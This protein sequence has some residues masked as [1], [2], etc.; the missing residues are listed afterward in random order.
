MR[1]D[2]SGLSPFTW[3]CAALLFTAL[4]ATAGYFGFVL[5][6]PLPVV[7]ASIGCWAG[8]WS[9]GV[10]GRTRLRPFLLICGLLPVLL[11]L[12][13]AVSHT[14]QAFDSPLQDANLQAIDRWLGFDWLT[15]QRAAYA[16]PHLFDLLG[17]AYAAFVPQIIAVPLVLCALG[18]VR[19][20]DVVLGAGILA[21]LVVLAVGAALPA[22]GAVSFV[23]GAEGH[24]AYH[25]GATPL[26]TFKALRDGS[27]RRVL[28]DGSGG[29]ITCPSFHCV[30]AVICTYGA[31]GIRPLRWP[32][33]A[34]NAAMIVAAVTH[35]A[36]YLTDVIVGVGLGALAVPASI[37]AS[38]ASLALA[39]SARAYSQR[40]AAKGEMAR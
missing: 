40:P 16:Q 11:C 35:G 2:A 20:A 14:V 22:M 21:Q 36:H 10:K 34:L 3:A 25:G 18:Q 4:V 13:L 12:G 32:V 15:F 31:W 33:C 39:E 30:V 24:L 29:L 19:R 6:A 26:E 5:E 7:L 28:T 1:S 37:S 38:S 23:S 8:A 9:A 17:W 27:L